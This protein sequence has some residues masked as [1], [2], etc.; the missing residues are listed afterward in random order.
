LT[1]QFRL[2]LARHIVGPSAPRATACELPV[3]RV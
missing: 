1:A 3:N 2:H